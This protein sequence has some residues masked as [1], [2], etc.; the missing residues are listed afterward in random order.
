MWACGAQVAMQV[1]YQKVRQVLLIFVE[2]KQNFEQINTLFRLQ[3]TDCRGVTFT[4]QDPSAH[5][6]AQSCCGSTHEAL[7]SVAAPQVGDEHHDKVKHSN[8]I[9]AH[10]RKEDEEPD[11]I[12][13]SFP[14]ACDLNRGNVITMHRQYFC[15][16]YCMNVAV[17]I[18]HDILAFLCSFFFS[19]QKTHLS[20]RG[21]ENSFNSSK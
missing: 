19:F 4:N 12:H 14:D 20:K 2:P 7:G 3:Q 5:L 15:Y 9:N 21:N 11:N 6:V 16:K 1:S 17:M 10:A 13:N 8:P 18:M